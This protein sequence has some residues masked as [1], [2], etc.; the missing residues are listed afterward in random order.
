MYSVPDNFRYDKVGPSYPTIT[1][2]DTKP[3]FSNLAPK[4]DH[5]GMTDSNYKRVPMETKHVLTLAE[6]ALKGE[7]ISDEEGLNRATSS[8]NSVYI[9][10]DTLYIS[11]TKG[12]IYGREWRQN[13]EYILQNQS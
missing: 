11:E 4:T 5:P 9:Y 13:M 3:D 12:P 2:R 1:E 8:D 10:R 6:K 7:P